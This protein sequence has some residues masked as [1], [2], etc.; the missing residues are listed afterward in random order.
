MGSDK[1]RAE[2]IR[3]QI[4]RTIKD[5]IEKDPVFYKKFSEKIA[6]IIKRMR[7]KKIAD[8]EALKQL[9]LINDEVNNKKDDEIPEKIK[10]KEGV[11]ILYRNLQ[12]EFAV[13]KIDDEKFQEIILD[14]VD[15][16]K[17]ETIVDWYRNSEVKRIIYNKLDDY[18]YDEVIQKQSIKL[19]SKEVKNI[20][21]KTIK[22]AVENYSI[23]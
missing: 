17:K 13:H 22:L 4:D 11:D 3:A 6:E 15:V 18:L 10:G 8:I 1:S 23:I 12:D 14:M 20:I 19:T 5:Q 9:K 16:L 21:D 7:E 2:A